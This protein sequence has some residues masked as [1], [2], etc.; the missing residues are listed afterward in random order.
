M[1]GPAD[2]TS[3]RSY[4]SDHGNTSSA[5]G[6]DQADVDTSTP[7]TGRKLNE[8]TPSSGRKLN[9]SGGACTPPSATSSALSYASQIFGSSDL[10]PHDRWMRPE[11]GSAAS[12]KRSE[13]AKDGAKRQQPRPYH[14]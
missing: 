9:N 2:L 1:R 3:F 13:S 4:T 12:I 10:S 11:K 5:T 8:P 6:E 7:S 14:R